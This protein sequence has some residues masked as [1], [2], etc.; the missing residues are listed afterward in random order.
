MKTTKCRHARSSIVGR[1]QIANAASLAAEV[2]RFT[3]AT[4]SI[5]DRNAQLVIRASADSIA[6]VCPT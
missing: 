5:D 1:A 2:D 3:L 6:R 4:I